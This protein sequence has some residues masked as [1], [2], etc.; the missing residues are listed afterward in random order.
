MIVPQRC[1]AVFRAKQ[2]PSNGLMIAGV[3]PK[4]SSALVGFRERH[5]I[6]QPPV[7]IDYLDEPAS[8]TFP[9]I[10]NY[11]V[12]QAPRRDYRRS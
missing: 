1:G 7:G 5:R 12:S 4:G 6:E 11:I 3:G 10:A 9:R 8:P 2:N